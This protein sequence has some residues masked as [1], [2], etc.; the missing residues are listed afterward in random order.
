[1]AKLGGL[2]GELRAQVKALED[3]LRARV[4]GPDPH[5][6]QADVYEEWHAQ[7]ESAL[8]AERTATSWQAWR[9]E[10]VMQAAAAWVLLTVFARFCEDNELVRPV[11]IAGHTKERRQLAHDAR[12]T[13]F[14]QN[15][16]HNDRDWLTHIAEHFARTPAT[17]GLVDD[18]S[19]L[20]L[21]APSG[22]AASKLLEFWWEQDSDGELLHTF[23]TPGL[24]TRFLGDL[25]EHLS[26]FARETYALRQTPEFVEEFIL[27]Q[28]MEPALAERPLEGF[29][30]I[31]PTCGSG[32][33]LLGAFHRLLVRWSKQAPNMDSRA[34]VQRALD[35]VHG[36]DINPFAVAIARFRLIVATLKATGELSL[37]NAP[38]FRL[39]LAA[40]DSLLFG[41]PQQ[42][43]GDD[44]FTIDESVF[45]YSTE[46]RK[47]LERLLQTRGGGEP[48]VYDVVVGNP[49]YISVNDPASRRMYREQYRYCHG[50][51][52]YAI[53]FMELFFNLA[54][55]DDRPGWIGKITSNAFM[56][57]EFGKPIIEEFLKYRDLRAV[58]DTSGA[59]IPG[60]GTPT[61][62]L[63]GRNQGRAKRTVRAVLGVRGEPGRPEVAAKGS[64]WRSIVDHIGEPGFEN[65]WVSVI[66]LDREVLSTHPWSLSGGGAVDLTQE[67]ERDTAHIN[68][69][70]I[71]VGRTTHTGVDDAFYVPSTTPRTLGLQD[72]V[73]P[74]VL[75]EDV[76]DFSIDPHI[77]TLFPYNEQG[78]P[79]EPTKAT[80]R[81]FWRN[82]ALL[83][84]RVD[85]K[86]T[87]QERGL[88]WFDHSM[89][90]KKR[91]RTP[92]SIAFAFVAT[93]NH[94]VLD[95]GGKVFKQT[96]PVIKLPEG[97][98]EDDHLELL[99][100]LNS[101]VAC[102]WLKQN[103]HNKGEGGG[104]RV[105]AGYAARGEPWRESYEFTGTTLQKFPLP[106]KLPL[107]RAHSLDS[108]AQELAQL[109]PQAVAERA[110]PTR[111]NLNAA[112]AEHDHI[113]SLM[114]AH[115]EELDWECY[116]LYGLVAEDLTY[117]SK[118]PGIESAERAFSIDLA[119]QVKN[120]S[121]ETTWFSH[122]NHQFT[123]ITEIPAHWPADYREV[124]QRRLD[125]IAE[126]KK[127]RLLEKPEYKRRWAIEPWDKR[128]KAALRDWLLDRLEDRRFWF[129]R[130][131]RPHPRS[132]IQLAD[133][134][135][136][137]AD[138]RAVLQLWS[139]RPDT[140][141][142][143]ALEDL[144]ADQTVPYLAAYRYK[145]SGLEA[146]KAWE[147]TWELQ[148]KEDAGELPLNQAT[149]LPDPPIPVPPKYKPADFAK[150]SY[151]SHRGKLDVPKERF[152]LYPDANRET[153]PSPLLGW[154]GWDHAQQALALAA[155]MNE[156][157]GD[158]WDDGRMVPLIAGLAEL[159]PWVRQW[160]GEV[161][162]TYG[163]SLAAIIDEELASR[164]Q[165]AGATLDDLA[166][167]RP[168][169][170]GRGRRRTTTKRGDAQQ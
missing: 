113:R 164:S 163:V 41:A 149:K 52:T 150:T 118:L 160:H 98:S 102:F 49:P 61:V 114:N 121:V 37:E 136:R 103:S 2:V 16:E 147:H 138:F 72:E 127:I 35:G 145:P 70:Q 44:L 60:H 112:K 23:D 76:R 156:R 74:V 137:D 78:E 62:I 126:N 18:F 97:A 85:Y 158:G 8:K 146:R 83:S 39:N 77:A 154:A 90:F 120:G 108:L 161:D 29:R 53:P 125:I 50:Q 155:I 157:E 144:L 133:E 63:V 59:Y 86:Q 25:Y 31:D 84:S 30:L 5:V 170:T 57:R 152:I 3:D 151:W 131:G 140:P 109:T 165:R 22:D 7:W 38:N 40:G 143:A 48:A 95:R 27:D 42:G 19:P 55:S 135:D 24:D 9:D 54:K 89:F 36:V 162:P 159:A 21:V 43:L 92:L 132:V 117:Q 28:T 153:D 66:D 130:E 64:V 115:Q 56:K 100:V 51:Y 82:K 128:V 139:G 69:R 45:A 12:R 71:L 47:S 14:Q 106:A 6:R 129:D 168:A 13:Y 79:R 124:V 20:H 105:D 142:A 148:R 4:D 111:E 94:F 1:M 87:L 11:W 167:W 119:R 134:V 93:H 67:I 65:D 96:A 75:G 68:D 122:H 81:F 46:D 88:R 110:T 32:H 123:P 107:K 34:L 73:V 101:S 141:T 17:A 99:G 169:T 10:R 15:P 116:R 58:I 26:K 80:M 166:G 33:F 104:A 91:Y